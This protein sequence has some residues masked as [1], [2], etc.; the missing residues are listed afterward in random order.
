LVKPA[1]STSSTP[2]VIDAELPSLAAACP[3]AVTDAASITPGV[4]LVEHAG[5][6]KPGR[7]LLLIYDISANL[8]ELHGN[9]DWMVRCYA[10]NRPF[11]GTVSSITKMRGLGAFGELPLFHGG[12]DDQHLSIIHRVKDVEGAAAVDEAATLFVGGSVEDINARLAAGTARPDDFKVVMGST[13]IRLVKDSDGALDLA[14]ADADRWH[15]VGGPGATELAMLPP[16]FDTTGKFRDGR[17]LG[18]D[19][20]VEGYNFAR[21]WHQN[22]AWAHAMNGLANAAAA[23]AGTNTEEA[24]RAKELSAFAGLHAATVHYVEAVEAAVA[25][26]VGGPGQEEAPSFNDDGRQ[27][28]EATGGRRA[29]AELR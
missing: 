10:V 20:E 11:P 19:E 18:V 16:Q 29:A 12:M 3:S 23:A 8:M 27:A 13:A 2:G 6:T 17:G 21:F 4:L 15:F 9:E 24:A 26:G 14:P 1:C 5:F 28:E 22:A 25:E 7:S